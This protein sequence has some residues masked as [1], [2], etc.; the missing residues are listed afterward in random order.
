MSVCTAVRGDY[1]RTLSHQ[2]ESTE[3]SPMSVGIT[4]RGPALQRTQ[5]DR[6]VVHQQSTPNRYQQ[7][8]PAQPSD[9]TLTC[10]GGVKKFGNSI[11][12]LLI[13]YR[14]DVDPFP[15]FG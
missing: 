4:R 1:S 15:N 7:P 10:F 9:M 14:P 3:E 13:V 5:Q 6:G 2:T 8:F 11:Q 12:I